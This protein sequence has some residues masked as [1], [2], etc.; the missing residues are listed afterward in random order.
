MR[1]SRIGPGH[2]GAGHRLLEEARRV[3]TSGAGCHRQAPLETRPHA[4]APMAAFQGGGIGGPG[5]DTERRGP[6]AERWR[7]QRRHPGPREAE[8][9]GRDTERRRFRCLTKAAAAA[10]RRR[11]RKRRGR[12]TE[13][14][15]AGRRTSVLPAPGEGVVRRGAEGGESGRWKRLLKSPV[16]GAR[17][18][19]GWYG[20]NPRSDAVCSVPLLSVP[21]VFHSYGKLYGNRFFMLVS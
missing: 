14:P 18:T 19:P 20:L 21:P 17:R 3:S 7:F 1:L 11:G 15:G 5:A 6:D 12:D 8:H 9:R 10:P 4:P 16:G 2:P 13:R